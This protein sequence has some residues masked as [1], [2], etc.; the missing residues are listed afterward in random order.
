MRV[1][2][3]ALALLASLLLVAACGKQGALTPVGR[4]AP[5]APV[6]TMRAPSPQQM[7]RTDAQAAP[8][9]ID[10]QTG[11]LRDRGEDPF[12]LPPPKR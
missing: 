3:P 9:R 7:L 6:G 8:A 2:V 12:N 1:P 4:P 10:D 5:V 11:Q